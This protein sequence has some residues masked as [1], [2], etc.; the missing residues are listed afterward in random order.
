[1]YILLQERDAAREKIQELIDE[2]IQL[3]QVTKSALQE[4]SA[5]VI[6]ED[7]E[8]EETNSGDNSLSEQLTNNAQARALKLELENRRLLSTIDLLKEHNFHESAA[9]LLELEKEKKKLTLKCEQ[10]HE[11]CERLTAQN[12][13]LENLFK[14]AL[15]ENRKLQDALDTGTVISDR[16]VQDLQNER[17]KISE[18]TKNIDS[19]TKEKQRVQTLC[20][21]VKKRADD[22]EKSL[23]QIMNELQ[24]LQLEVDKGKDIEKLG[25]EMKDK[26]AVLE[27]ENTGMQKEIGKLKEIIEV[28]C[29]FL[30]L[31]QFVVNLLFFRPRTY[32]WISK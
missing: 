29:I 21:V 2:N 17:L 24:T 5:V 32:N 18:L 1:M 23:G 15:Q 12:G 31:L 11:N 13:E 3:Q 7:S 22:A 16:Q 19:L 28:S 14:N 4:T 20:D 10:L 26:V 30:N 8:N 27:K 9:K 6:T 25:D